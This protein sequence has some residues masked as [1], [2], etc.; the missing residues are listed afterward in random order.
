MIS[1]NHP[2]CNHT[3][4][5]SP[6]DIGSVRHLHVRVDPGAITSF[7]RPTPEELLILQNGGCIAQT[8][9]S[10]QLPPSRLFVVERRASEISQHLSAGEAIAEIA[11]MI[12]E[13]ISDE[14]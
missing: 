5:P 4:A 13:L 1:F 9:V 7:W 12:D 10:P 8:I 11:A 14:G 3:I 6:L 2:L